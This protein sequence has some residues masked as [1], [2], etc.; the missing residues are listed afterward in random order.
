MG[1]GRVESRKGS[2]DEWNLGSLAIETAEI[3][4]I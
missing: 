1:A 3:V 4:K 2:L